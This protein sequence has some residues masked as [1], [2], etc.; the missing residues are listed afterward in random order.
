MSG[1]NSFYNRGGGI[2]FGPGV[3]VPRG[4]KILL[5]TN[6]ALFFLP[7]LVGIRGPELVT[8]F[9]LIPDEVF[10]RG[11][12]WQLFTYMFLHAS[13]FHVGFNMLMLWMF[14]SSVEHA[15]GTRDFAIF[16][17]I[18]GVGAALTQ[19][20]VDQIW[21]S[22]AP[23]IGASGAVYGLMLA[24][25]LMY[26]DRVI[27]VGLIFPLKMR[28]FMWILVGISLISGL[29]RRPG[30]SVAHFAHLGGILF[31]WLY[32]K[33]DWRLSAASRRLRGV[34]AREKMR[35]NTRREEQKQQ[36]ATS[37]D[38]ILDKI[39]THGIDSLTEQERRILRESSRH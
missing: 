1:P 6:V 9:G 2:R 11:K 4:V 35:Q 3:P 14:G 36:H 18:C 26:P 8:N 13:I 29:G 12:L 5:I 22:S 7:A 19:W 24:Y 17:T 20:G 15:W 33:Q 16:Y 30:D 31:G 10:G 28:Y 34:L 38:E 39:T 25:A 27:M 23:M 21:N 37:V 32:L